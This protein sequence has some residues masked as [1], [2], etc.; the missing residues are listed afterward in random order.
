MPVQL[1]APSLSRQVLWRR[2]LPT[3]PPVRSRW[4]NVEV[5]VEDNTGS[6][7]ALFKRLENTA[8]SAVSRRCM[9]SLVSSS[10]LICRDIPLLRARRAQC[11]AECWRDG[12]SMLTSVVAAP[13]GVLS[14]RSS[15]AVLPAGVEMA[16]LGCHA[17]LA[18][19]ANIRVR[20][21]GDTPPREQVLWQR[22]WWV[23]RWR[24]RGAAASVFS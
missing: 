23:V 1:P 6:E 11:R 10:R 8:F 3:S 24:A 21:R 16:H 4:S 20:P 22:R 17:A 12:G 18:K 19:A 5:E 2:R 14:T 7:F 13:D 9:S 15:V